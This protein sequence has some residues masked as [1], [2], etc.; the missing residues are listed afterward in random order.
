MK[1][2][3]I[4]LFIVCLFISSAAYSKVIRLPEENLYIFAHPV[5]PERKKTKPVPTQDPKDNDHYELLEFCIQDTMEYHLNDFTPLKFVTP[6]ANALNTWEEVTQKTIFKL[7]V[8]TE[9]NWYQ[10]DGENVISF[11]KFLPRD[12]IAFA[13]IY[14]NPDIIDPYTGFPIIVD[15]DIVF[16]A[17]HKWDVDPDGEGPIKINAFDVQNIATHELGHAI[18]LGDLYLEVYSELTMYGYGSKGETKKV[19]LEAGDILGA[20]FLYG[21]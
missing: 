21:L 7:G 8:N 4:F 15:A 13:A 3:L 20:Q 6:I 9:K 10:N 14:Y 1:K 5:E 2:I 17:L 19:S 16:N 11:V 18:G 12:Y